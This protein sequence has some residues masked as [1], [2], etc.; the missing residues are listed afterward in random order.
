MKKTI[1]YIG[2]DVHKNSIAVAI[3]VEDGGELRSYGTIGGKLADLDKLIKKLEHPGVELRFCYEAGPT[4]YVICRHLKKRAYPCEVIAPSLIP[5]KPSDQVK[6]NRRDAKMLARL[7]RA[8]ELTSVHVPDEEDEAIR[9]LER[10]RFSAVKD[11]RRARQRLKGLL[12]RQGLP[13]E[14]KTSWGPAHLNYLARLKMPNVA[15]QIAFEEYKTAITVAGE[16]LE[17][18]SKALEAQLDGWK[19]KPVVLALMTLRGIQT[20]NAMTLLAELGD[21]SRFTNPHQL[22][23]YLGLVSSEDST[24]DKR[25]QGGITKA[26]NEAGR[27]A[28]IEAVRAIAWKAQQRLHGRYHHLKAKG[29]KTQVVVTAIA[30]E[31][32]GFVWA[33]ACTAVGKA[34]APRVPK[35]EAPAHPQKNSENKSRQKKTYQLN[36]AIKYSASRKANRP[37]APRS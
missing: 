3:A 29:K 1:H 23:S 21:L 2:L 6:T 33:I 36:P 13:Y 30:R 5:Q 28:L 4:G 31:L 15:Q 35:P 8:G 7:F 37:A 9:D 26:G 10:A 19:W 12:L 18:L 11:Q 14:G 34:P 17:R 20:I 27:R 25:R 16:R 22:M 32:A 24:G